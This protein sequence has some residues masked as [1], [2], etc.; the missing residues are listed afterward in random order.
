MLHAE[1]IESEIGRL[2]DALSGS[3]EL[4][5]GTVRVTAVPI[6]VN[7]LLVP[8]APSL[9]ARHPKLRLEL[10]A[11]ARDVSLTRRE[12]DLALRLARP[13]TGGTK[14]VARR[15]GMLRY[16]VYAAASW[17]PREA[18]KLPWLGYDETMAHLPQARWIAETASATGE[19]IAA[20]SAARRRA[21]VVSSTP[22]RRAASASVRQRPTARR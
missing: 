21:T 13:R 1:R 19:P 20:W 10:V 2:D 18:A 16:D 11:E 7:H 9:L 17:P 22:R 4:V 3:D 14:I 5:S 6:L 8:A 15:V 12:D